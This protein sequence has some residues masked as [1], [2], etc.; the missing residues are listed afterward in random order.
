MAGLTKKQ[1]AFAVAYIQ[2]GNAT[3]AYRRAYSAGKMSIAALNVEASRTLSHPKISLRI[4][5]LRAP[6]LRK[7][8]LTVERTLQEVARVAYFDPRKLFREDGSLKRPDEWDD[9][10]AAVIGSMEFDKETGRASKLKLWDKNAALEKAMKHLGLF[11]KDNAQ[12]AE[13]LVLKVVA[14]KPVNS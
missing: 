9:D 1:E 13:S 14:A 11:E 7:A 2:T 6:A 8:E 5:A 3:E 12:Q 10:T 4:A